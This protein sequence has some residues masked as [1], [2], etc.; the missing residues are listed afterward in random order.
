MASSPATPYGR[1][2]IACVAFA[3]Y[4]VGGALGP[5]ERA[6][7]VSLEATPGRWARR[8]PA[9]VCPLRDV[10][11]ALSLQSGPDP[12]QSSL[13]TLAPRSPTAVQRRNAQNRGRHTT[14]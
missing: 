7:V 10:S 2:A 4:V 11:I 9:Q 8:S 5:P 14:I 3:V 1:F 12:P 13:S 6:Q